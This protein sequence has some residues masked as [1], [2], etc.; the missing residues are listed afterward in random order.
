[1]I[2]FLIAFRNLFRNLRRTISV[3]LTVTLGT[4]ALFCFD[5]F[6]NGVLNQYREGTIHAHYGHGQINTAGYRD[7]LYDTPS[8]HWI[9]NYSQIDT[10]LK[11]QPGV[12]HVFPRINF[13]ALVSNGKRDMGALGQGVDGDAEALFFYSLNIVKGQTLNDQPNG[14]LLGVG[15]AKALNV[16]P[17]DPVTVIASTTAGGMSHVQFTVTGIFHTGTK[18]FDDKIFRVDF[19]Q[20]QQLLKTNQVESISLGLRSLSDWGAV[21]KAVGEEFP[22]LEAASFE[23]LDTVYYQ[24]SVKWLKSQFKIVMIV[25]LVIV[26]LGIFNSISTTVLERKQEIGNLRAN[27]ESSWDIMK[28]LLCEGAV[29]GFVGSLMGILLSLLVNFTVLKNG[30]ALPPG[31]GLTRDFIAFLRLQPEMAVWTLCMG[32]GAAIMATIFSG[33]RV[34]RMSIGEAL[35]S[36]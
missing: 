21:S 27:G 7:N 24:H 15:L 34:A 10:F 20:A 29:I 32:T 26:S 6:I 1:M 28:L 35:R 30:I 3:L 17:G 31:P 2:L 8:D 14:I 22:E 25:I 19:R 16:Q 11:K 12:E 4:G 9:S 33:L 18:A 23:E 13:S 5:G 36:V